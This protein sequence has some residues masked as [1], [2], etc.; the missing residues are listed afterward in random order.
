M[1]KT[2]GD[3]NEAVAFMLARLSWY[4]MVRE[5]EIPWWEEAGFAVVD[6]EVLRA[7]SALELLKDAGYTLPEDALAMMAA[8][9]AQWR[10]HPAAF[11]AM[12]RYAIARQTE[13]ELAGWVVLEDG[14]TPRIP[15]AH[16]WWRPSSRW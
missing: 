11:D 15:P 4:D 7:R 14:S 1:V 8:A 5:E 16:W 10:A 9:D 6:E 12:F 13:D 3:F 2:V